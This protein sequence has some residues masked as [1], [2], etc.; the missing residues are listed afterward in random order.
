MTFLLPAISRLYFL[1]TSPISA[2]G[3]I[4]FFTLS[5]GHYPTNHTANKDGSPDSPQPCGYYFS[6]RICRDEASCFCPIATNGNWGRR[7]VLLF[8]KR[9]RY[10]WGFWSL[11]SLRCQLRLFPGNLSVPGY[12]CFSSLTSDG[13]HSP[14]WRCVGCDDCN[15]TRGRGL[16]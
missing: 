11:I 15:W 1:S 9:R 5:V 2:R 6:S 8:P 13:E 3:T 7:H 4:L 16:F 10:R 14:F 12:Q